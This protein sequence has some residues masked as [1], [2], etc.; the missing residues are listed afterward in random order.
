MISCPILTIATDHRMR[1]AIKKTRGILLKRFST[2]RKGR[3]NQITWKHLVM[4][5]CLVLILKTTLKMVL[6]G[7]NLIEIY[8]SVYY[9]DGFRAAWVCGRLIILQQS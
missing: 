7:I 6:I 9:M 2:F 8:V 4:L 1:I 3:R 5:G